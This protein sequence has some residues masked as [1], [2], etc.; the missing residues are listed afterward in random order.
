MRIQSGIIILI[1]VNTIFN[2]NSFMNICSSFLCTHPV[3]SQKISEQSCIDSIISKEIIIKCS[4][5][6]NGN[7]IIRNEQEYLA[8]FNNKSPQLECNDYTIPEIDFDK[9]TLIGI[10]TSV[11]GCSVPTIDRSVFKCKDK[12]LYI[13]SLSITKTGLCKMLHKIQI[14]FLIDQIKTTDKVEFNIKKTT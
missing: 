4:Q 9:Y 13:V 2:A 10:S 3:D 14:W 1:V 5:S 8:L 7:Y 12:K 6:K 11:D